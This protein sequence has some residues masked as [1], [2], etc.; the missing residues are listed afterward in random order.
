MR[1][2]LTISPNALPGFVGERA[3][4]ERAG[5]GFHVTGQ[6]LARALSEQGFDFSLTLGGPLGFGF[7]LAET[8][9][10]ALRHWRSG[11]VIEVAYRLERPALSQEIQAARDKAKE[12]AGEMPTGALEISDW[13]AA[14]ERALGQIL[15]ADGH[16][17]AVSNTRG[18][19]VVCLYEA[20]DYRI[21]ERTR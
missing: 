16:D 7:Y 18:V 21:I 9:E 4:G 2:T 14:H 5:V 6:A 11:T 20:A 3:A 8:H 17:G 15:Q 12:Q 19:R 13:L 10:Q 1:T